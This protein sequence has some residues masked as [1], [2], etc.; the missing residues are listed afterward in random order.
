MTKDKKAI[1]KQKM[2]SKE[3][4][5]KDFQGEPYDDSYDDG[6]TQDRE[7]R[8]IIC[9]L[10]FIAFLVGMVLCAQY[11]YNN[12]DITMLL[13]SYN[14]KG[15]ACQGDHHLLYLPSLFSGDSIWENSC[16]VSNCPKDTESVNKDTNGGCIDRNI[17]TYTTG[18]YFKRYCLPVYE[19]SDTGNETEED[20][21]DR[22]D[23]VIKKLA[24]KKAQQYMNDIAYAYPLFFYSALIAL[25]LGYIYI[26]I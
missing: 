1:S 25:F 17:A 2:G 23:K 4:G 13:S 16:C 7:C 19:K 21:A 5:D 8:D 24:E 10:L 12:G 20:Y 22:E 11:G 26:Y 9:C 18:D 6:P 14:S 15:N 3:L